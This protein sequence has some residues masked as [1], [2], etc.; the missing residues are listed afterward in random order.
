MERREILQM[1]KAHEAPQEIVELVRVKVPD[2]T[3]VA[4]LRGLW[5][6]LSDL[7]LGDPE[8][9]AEDDGTLLQIGEAA[10]RVGLSLRS[11][12]YYDEAGLV[13]PSAR[14]DGN[15]RLYSERDIER[16]GM[17]KDMKPFGLSI[18]EMRIL[19]DL[20]DRSADRELL[21]AAEAAQ[22]AAG[23]ERVAARGDETIVRLE[24]DLEQTHALRLRIGEH[25]A[26]CS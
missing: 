4:G 23:L 15:F 13:H 20:L 21:S 1:L 25:L 16:L 6:H 12:R 8:E 7:P 26:R 2:R 17:V 11:V 14:T 10:D 24:R 22:V 9:P 5:E 3:R 18:D 19:T